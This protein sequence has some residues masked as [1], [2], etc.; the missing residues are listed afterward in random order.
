MA[1]KVSLILVVAVVS[2]LAL[3]QDDY[4]QLNYATFQ[5]HNKARTNPEYFAKLARNDIENRFVYRNGQPTN[6]LCLSDDFVPKS[7]KCSFTMGTIEGVGAWREAANDLDYNVYQL[8][9]LQWSEGLAQACYD[10]IRDIGPK[11]MTDHTGS[12]GSRPSD[13]ILKYV[14]ASMT[15][16]N[17][18]FVD[19][20]TGEDIV[21]Q[22]LVDDGVLNRG[23][24]TNIMNEGFTHL[25]VSCGCHTHYTE[26]CCF[27]YGTNVVEK[28]FSKKADVAPQ[29]KQCSPYDKS[30][31]ST[32]SGN[33]KVTPQA[34]P[35]SPQS[36]PSKTPAQ[37]P[38]AEPTPK[39]EP[40]YGFTSTPVVNQPKPAPE[41]SSSPS[42]TQT[43][44]P[45][46]STKPTTT[47]PSSS[48]QPRPSSST[49]QPYDNR[50]NP[51][52][53]R[54]PSSAPSSTPSSQSP[55]TASPSTNSN[56]P[57]PIRPQGYT[58]PDVVE[59]TSP[60]IPGS[61]SNVQQAV[62]PTAQSSRGN[63]GSQGR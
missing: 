41:S 14:T 15:G 29:L 26:M 1:L 52:Y 54:A 3:A 33:F 62:K 55:Q 5:A 18:G 36:Q 27:A 61:L 40:V 17:L 34:P 39:A 57:G 19:V 59:P 7:D 37:S 32:S 58:Y 12:D 16:E 38:P 4:S 44:Q 30:T 23:H 35:Q 50:Q 10:H 9:P 51:Y 24:R 25:G 56:W 21:L 31:K 47:S 45:S 13:R 28:D 6:T 63:Q 60:I 8:K 53:T 22:L 42:S 20:V 11:G 48:Q 43:T 49:S 46:S 2:G